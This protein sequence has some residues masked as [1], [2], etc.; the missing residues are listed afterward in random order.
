M[1]KKAKE[2]C[3]NIIIYITLLAFIVQPIAP[4]L[5]NP[6]ID[7]AGNGVPI[8]EINKPGKGGVS[9]NPFDRFDVNKNGLIFNNS[10]SITNTTL[11]G[12]IMGNKNLSGGPARLILA[13][14]IGN[15]PSRLNGYM[16]IAGQR[17]GLIIAN[18][19]GISGGGFGFINAGRVALTTG[20]PILLDNGDLSYN[21]NKGSIQINGQGLDATRTEKIDILAQAVQ[22]NAGIWANEVNIVTGTNKIHPSGA[23]EK[24]APAVPAQGAVALDIGAL[25]GMYAGKIKLIGTEKGLGVNSRGT[26]QS[27][28]DFTLDSQGNIV[29]SGNTAAG[30]SV[31]IK[32]KESVNNQKDIIAQGAVSID[33]GQKN[34]NSGHII[35]QSNLALSAGQALINSG[36]IAAEKTMQIKTAQ[37]EN[38]EGNI[39]A[40][41]TIIEAKQIHNGKKGRIAHLGNEQMKITAQ[42]TIHN[43]GLIGA[44]GAL[45]LDAAE[46][47]NKAG[48]I[49]A[50][51]DMNIN[52]QSMENKTGAKIISSDGELNIS[53]QQTLANDGTIAGGEA[54]AIKANE[55]TNNKR[56]F[57]QGFVRV[58]AKTLN[59][60]TG[61]G[62]NGQKIKLTAADQIKNNA[63]IIASQDMAIQ[64]KNINAAGGTIAAGIDGQG[65][66]KEQGTLSISGE[67]IRLKN[68]NAAAEQLTPKGQR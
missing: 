9:Y 43:E 46:I 58:N 51:K 54:L 33:A 5:A 64:A 23:V 40:K 53:A 10:L 29:L 24:I 52:V 26:I 61:A 65:Q 36:T 50:Q 59:N 14:V 16:E 19:N 66:V 2:I 21:I 12:Y 31:K 7:A 63:S 60:E 45:A 11:A 56:L 55:L 35:S 57:S 48:Q 67:Q 22:I 6:K 62:I 47:I 39:E 41:Q 1:R 25:G 15:H 3:K 32:A 8:V 42:E 37:L 28:G 34:E 30:G 20:K 68:E 44:N 49:S 4:V 17:A 27:T 13:E 38:K 18:P